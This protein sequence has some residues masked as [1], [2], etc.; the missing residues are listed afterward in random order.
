MARTTQCPIKNCPLRFHKDG[1]LFSLILKS[2]RAGR[3]GTSHSPYHIR[4][5]NIVGAYPCGRPVAEISSSN[6]KKTASQF[7]TRRLCLI[8]FSLRQTASIHQVMD[9]K[10]Q[11]CLCILCN[12]L[13]NCIGTP[14]RK[15]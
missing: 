13:K 4:Y 7:P 12:Q 10:F 1:F 15:R 9:L 2:T 3:A 11:C 8:N 6:L 14:Q 5:A